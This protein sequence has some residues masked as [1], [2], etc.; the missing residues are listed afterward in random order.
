MIS[1]SL[2]RGALGRIFFDQKSSW[3]FLNFFKDL[4]FVVEKLVDRNTGYTTVVSVAN[5]GVSEFQRVVYDCG[6]LLDCFGS[7][8]RQDHTLTY[9]SWRDDHA[10]LAGA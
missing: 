2:C 1:Q 4:L 9:A 5:G 3:D 10:E 8:M 6:S 7:Q